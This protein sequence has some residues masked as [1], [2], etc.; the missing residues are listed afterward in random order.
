MYLQP[1]EKELIGE[2]VVDG[3]HIRADD[4]ARRIQWLMKHHLRKI[5]ISKQWGA[6][7]TLFQDPDDL[8]YWELTYPRSEMHGGGAPA[9]KCISTELAAT[10]YDS[11]RR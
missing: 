3:G 9:L 11:V 7:K 1:S 8:R 6:W 5:G 2:W 4:T 10:E